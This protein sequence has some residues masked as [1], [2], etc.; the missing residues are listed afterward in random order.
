V[1]DGVTGPTATANPGCDQPKP[2][3]LFGT[4]VDKNHGH[5]HETVTALTHICYITYLALKGNKNHV[6][7]SS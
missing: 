4:T 3:N 2:K 1:E 6:T 7:T 5:D